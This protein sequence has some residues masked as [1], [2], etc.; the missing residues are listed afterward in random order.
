MFTD[1]YNKSYVLIS[2]WYLIYL[3]ALSSILHVRFLDSTQ[4]IIILPYVDYFFVNKIQP[5]LNGIFS[6]ENL[7]THTLRHEELKNQNDEA[8]FVMIF[9][10]DEYKKEGL[11]ALPIINRIIKE[12]VLQ[13]ALPKNQKYTVV[14]FNKANQMISHQIISSTP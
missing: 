14:I 9:Y 8:L 13:I 4:S 10:N 11:N 3:F 2:M 1:D 5:N 7:S 6:A 12:D